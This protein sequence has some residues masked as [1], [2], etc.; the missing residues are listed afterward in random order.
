M[1]TVFRYLL[2]LS[3]MGCGIS[4]ALAQVETTEVS[5]KTVGESPTSDAVIPKEIPG[6]LKLPPGSNLPAVLILHGSNGI[7]GRGDSYAQALNAA[8]IA[9]LEIDMWK[10]RNIINLRS[11]P[12][13]FFDNLP[14]VWGGWAFLSNQPRINK[15]NIGVLGFSWGGTLAVIT[16]FN[17]KPKN[18]PDEI[19]SAKFKAHAPLYPGCTF[20]LGRA[21][22]PLNAKG[23]SGSPILLQVGAKDDYDNEGD[24]AK[25]NEA[26]PS[27][28][29]RVVVID[30]ATHGFDGVNSSSFYDPLAKDGAGGNIQ[31]TPN[32]L[33]ANQARENVVKFF[34]ESL[35]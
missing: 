31:I 11:R 27:A 16:G 33:A 1:K 24:C 8:G 6:I 15:Q 10:P 12:K 5:V 2:A 21:K 7:D 14:D 18:A 29:L 19:K 4:V 32:Q 26:F 30:N 9:T 34:K 23:P 28:P 20:M 13:S 17:G 3:L 35:R 22:A 25:L